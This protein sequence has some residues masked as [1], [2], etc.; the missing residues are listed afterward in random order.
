MLVIV[1]Y[2]ILYPLAEMHSPVRIVC[3]IRGRL[4]F[5]IRLGNILGFLFLFDQP[6]LAIVVHKCL[7]KSRGDLA[8]SVA[9]LHWCVSPVIH[10]ESGLIG[11]DYLAC[12]V[13]AILFCAQLSALF[14][15]LC[16]P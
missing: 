16:E 11:H 13:Q 14:D 4:N 12:S 3:S 8:G 7:R 15:E 5:W 2:D 1:S 6:Q 10:R 9:A